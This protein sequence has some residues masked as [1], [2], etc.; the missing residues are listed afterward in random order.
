MCQRTVGRAFLRFLK[1]RRH[2]VYSRPVPSCLDHFEA[3]QAAS[4]DPTNLDKLPRAEGS[5][6]ARPVVASKS[7]VRSGSPRNNLGASS[8]AET[9]ELKSKKT[10]GFGTRDAPSGGREGAAADS[11]AASGQHSGQRTAQRPAD[12]KAASLGD[13]CPQAAWHRMKH[14]GC[15][16]APITHPRIRHPE[17][18]IGRGAADL[19]K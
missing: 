8:P 2:I 7:A 14:R 12:R 16:I 6:T 10:R 17:E 9:D 11:T 3:G 18:S 4:L 13:R 1:A 19:L 5:G 15:V